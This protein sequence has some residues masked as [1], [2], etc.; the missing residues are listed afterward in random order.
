MEARC[1]PPMLPAAPAPK[2]RGRKKAKKIFEKAPRGLLPPEYQQFRINDFF[3]PKP[4][5]QRGGAGGTGAGFL[6]PNELGDK[7]FIG[8]FKPIFKTPVRTAKAPAPRPKKR[9]A[10]PFA[11]RKPP[12]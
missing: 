4:N 5:Q 11:P 7:S 9:S 3:A 10:K 1:A 2:P 12:V 6:K 8:A